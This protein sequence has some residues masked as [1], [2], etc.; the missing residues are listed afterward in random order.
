MYKD[1]LNFTFF[2]FVSSLYGFCE[3]LTYPLPHVQVSL[4]D[5]GLQ[6]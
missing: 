3:V 5:Q 2:S 4:A 1:G 6:E